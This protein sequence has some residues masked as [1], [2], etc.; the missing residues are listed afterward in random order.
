ME[1]LEL[2]AAPLQQ[3]T[4]RAAHCKEMTSKIHDLESRSLATGPKGQTVEDDAVHARR[5]LITLKG[6]AGTFA[7]RH[8]NI[9]PTYKRREIDNGHFSVV[10]CMRLGLPFPATQRLADC[11]CKKPVEGGWHWF[12]CKKLGVGHYAHNACTHVMMQLLAKI[13]IRVTKEPKVNPTSTCERADVVIHEADD[14]GG[15]AFFD[16]TA[17]NPLAKSFQR[18][19]Y[20][21]DAPSPGHENAQ[22][23]NDDTSSETNYNVVSIG[24]C[25]AVRQRELEKIAKYAE[26]LHRQGHQFYPFV[27]STLGGWGNACKKFFM[28]VEKLMPHTSGASFAKWK[29]NFITDMCCTFVKAQ[30]EQIIKGIKKTRRIPD[31]EEVV[32]EDYT[33]DDGFYVLNPTGDNAATLADTPLSDQDESDSESESDS[34][35]GLSSE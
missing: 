26:T 33:I 15:K 12:N 29:S 1:T 25:A 4:T 3:L 2:I 30:G 6:A 11:S 27:I 34:I 35:T 13:G 28:V 10:C 22:T 9:L 18:V 21:V 5:Q 14:L 32:Y 24:M 8:L 17:I 19:H 7:G 23:T 20:T 31:Y 16:F